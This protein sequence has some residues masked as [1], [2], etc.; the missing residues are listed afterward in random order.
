M[1]SQCKQIMKHPQDQIM[2]FRYKITDC[3]NGI[4]KFVQISLRFMH[5]LW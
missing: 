4:D 5:A 1:E 2:A 3:H